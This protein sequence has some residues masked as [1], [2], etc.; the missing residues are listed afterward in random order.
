MG[1]INK[2]SNWKIYLNTLL[3]VLLVG[4]ISITFTFN[5]LTKEIV[6]RR[7][8]TSYLGASVLNE[9]LNRVKDLGISLTTRVKFRNLIQKGDFNGAIDIVRDIPSNFNFIQAVHL[10]SLEGESLKSIP[11]LNQSQTYKKKSWFN[12]LKAELQPTL[13]DIYKSSNNKPLVSFGFPIRKR[14]Q[15]SIILGH[16]VLDIDVSN[17]TSWINEL[18]QKSSGNMLILDNNFKLLSHSSWG[19]DSILKNL[20]YLPEV[21]LLKQKINGVK[22]FNSNNRIVAFQNLPNYNW[23]II[24]EEKTEI[25]FKGRNETILLLTAM[26]L[27]IMLGAYISAKL[28]IKKNKKII[29][30]AFQIER[31]AHQLKKKNEELK[32]FTSMASHDLKAP[33]R[34]ISILANVLLEDCDYLESNDREMLE[35]INDRVVK[36]TALI[37]G[38]LEIARIGQVKQAPE[39]ILISKLIEEILSEIDENNVVKYT[40]NPGDQEVY[41]EHFYLEQLFKN[42]ISNSIKYTNKDVVIINILIKE[43]DKSYSFDYSDN[44]PGIPSEL[45]KSIFKPFQKGD[46]NKKNSHGVGLAIVQK[47]ISLKSTENITIY[48]PDK[49]G[50]GFQFSLKK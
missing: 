18:Q 14:N 15:E 48:N 33:I 25:A 21:E 35:K 19:T 23:K 28:N 3:P 39:R 8:S 50:V 44:G 32:Q 46:E 30:Q 16:L 6:E 20:A 4:I 29:A 45:H 26:L 10:L 40:V 12:K 47:I 22:K 24:F 27:I 11:Y 36:M 37:N 38:F 41:L 31:S 49:E 42:L 9:K 7:S 1:N 34:G 43:D 2:Y 17:I 5:N 13:S